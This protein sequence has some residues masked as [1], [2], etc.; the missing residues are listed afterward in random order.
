V[1]QP[2]QPERF[3]SLYCRNGVATIFMMF[4][5]LSGWRNVSITESKT[6][7]DWGLQVRR[8][9]DKDYPKAAKVHLMMDNLNTHSGASLY[10]AFA[11]EDEP[12]ALEDRTYICL[13]GKLQTAVCQTRTKSRHLPC[14]LLL[15]LHHDH[16][17]WV[18][19]WLPV[20]M[21]ERSRTILQV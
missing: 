2:G 8:L 5:P 14:F 10:E 9:L 13:A 18:L 12:K 17:K 7:L 3:D 20:R 15:G 16:H 19:K 4:E 6:R 11:P 21:N 1:A